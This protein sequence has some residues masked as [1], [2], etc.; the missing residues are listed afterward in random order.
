MGDCCMGD[1]VNYFEFNR[2]AWHTETL[3]NLEY[4]ESEF[5]GLKESTPLLELAL[6]KARIDD[7]D[8]DSKDRGNVVCGEN[9][10]LK[11]DSSEFRLQCHTSCGADHVIAN[12]LLFLL[13]LNFV[14]SHF[15]TIN[16][17]E[18]N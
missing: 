15:Y 8:D 14:R 10:K 16:N 9:K 6:W 17:D 18:D 12:I 7:D 5:Q 1:K 2:Q 13:P 4:Y 11:I 3:A